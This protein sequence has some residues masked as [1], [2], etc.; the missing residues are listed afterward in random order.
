MSNERFASVWDAIED[1]PEAVSYTHLD[2][3]K[4]QELKQSGELG[5]IVR[6]SAR[7]MLRL[8]FWRSVSGGASILG[9]LKRGC[10][11]A[12]PCLVASLFF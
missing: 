9:F 11:T 1:T 8:T 4:R 2:V 12:L 7:F 5:L 10:T 6:R 3:Y